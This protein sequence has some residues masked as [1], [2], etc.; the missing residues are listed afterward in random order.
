MTF[1]AACDISY[2]TRYVREGTFM[3]LHVVACVNAG[4]GRDDVSRSMRRTQ[5]YF[6]ASVVGFEK[7]MSF[8]SHG[9]DRLGR[10]V[11]VLPYVWYGMV[12][13]VWYG[14]HNDIKQ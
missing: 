4:F 11:S 8:F 10:L 3:C 9:F 12:W 6:V 5:S 7:L 13:Y 14:K 1:F 2:R